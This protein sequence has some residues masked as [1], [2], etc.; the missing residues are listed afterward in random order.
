MRVAKKLRMYDSTYCYNLTSNIYTQ[1]LHYYLFEFNLD[2]C[3]GSCN[4]LNDLSIKVSVANK[5]ENL[6][7]CFFDMIRGVRESEISAKRISCEYK[8]KLNGRK[9]NLNQK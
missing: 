2:G 7:I 5:I 3:V 8:C 1:G 9:C 4:T 6:N